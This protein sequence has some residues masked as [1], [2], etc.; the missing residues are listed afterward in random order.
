M[1]KFFK[2]YPLRDGQVGRASVSGEMNL[3]EE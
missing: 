3:I 1:D 2:L